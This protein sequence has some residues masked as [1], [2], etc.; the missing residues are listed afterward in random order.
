[1][2]DKSLVEMVLKAISNKKRLEI[3]ECI[4]EEKFLIKGELIDRF[5]LQRAGLDFHLSAL[6]EAG[7]IGLLEKPV[8][9][10]VVS[11][12]SPPRK[13][14]RHSAPLRVTLPESTVTAGILV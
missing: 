11:S 2:E 9:T 3:L 6:E 12:G 4:Q 10:C 5:N 14:T 1:M 8:P 7:L 13:N